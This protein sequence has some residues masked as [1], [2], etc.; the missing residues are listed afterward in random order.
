MISSI[1]H[2]KKLLGGHIGTLLAS[3]LMF[4]STAAAQDCEDLGSNPEYK[5]LVDKMNMEIQKEDYK[6][7]RKTADQI[8][9]IC[10]S[11]PSVNYA[12][13]KIYQKLN[14]HKSAHTYFMVATDNSEKFAVHKD[15]LKDMWY[16]RY[17]SEF[18]EVL[19][20]KSGK[21]E[22]LH[23]ETLKD[24]LKSN[25]LNTEL[26]WAKTVMWTGAGIGITGVVMAAVGG[27]LMATKR[28]L[29][30]TDINL[31]D[32]KAT[33][34]DADANTYIAGSILLGL[35]AGTAVA[36]AIVTGIGGFKYTK[37]KSANE[38]Q[39]NVDLSVNLSYNY[40][41]LDMTF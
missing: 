18:P 7:A 23:K 32:Y 6:T 24:A 10:P 34:N 22:Q 11:V 13:G 35:G 3:I 38:I 21:I 15:L 31:T 5:S 28:K 25:E 29:N 39:N 16:A 17:E 8:L 9:R 33:V 27:S 19:D 2:K 1:E 36:G 20:L 26:D 14:D 12:M 37:L 30:V 4:T 40:I 41:S